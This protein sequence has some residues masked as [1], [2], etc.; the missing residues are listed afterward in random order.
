MDFSS[1]SPKTEDRPR[2]R[3]RRLKRA[4]AWTIGVLALL[5]LLA[6]T[7]P[8]GW[9]PWMAAAWIRSTIGTPELGGTVEAVEY[10][11]PRSFTLRG[12]RL[13]GIPGSP[14]LDRVEA[15]YSP[16]GLLRGHRLDSLDATGFRMDLGAALPPDAAALFRNR[17]VSGE[18]H[19][20]A[21]GDAPGAMVARLDGR[22]LDWRLGG[23]IRIGVSFTNGFELAGLADVS[24]P[25]TPWDAR[26]AFVSAEDGWKVEAALPAKAFD[27]RADFNSMNAVPFA[28]FSEK[29]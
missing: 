19:A 6:A 1:P 16:M 18:L 7:F 24:L 29:E 15:R 14:S 26:A 3:R 12:L 8:T 20:K 9:G 10:V 13:R 23:D 27:K 2:P 21:D 17:R 11:S 5:A 22:L 28:E 4:L 25:G